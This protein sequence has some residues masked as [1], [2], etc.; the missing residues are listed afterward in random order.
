MAYRDQVMGGYAA[1]SSNVPEDIE[2][3]FSKGVPGWMIDGV[4]PKKAHD[5][6]IPSASQILKP[7]QQ[8]PTDRF[9]GNLVNSKATHESGAD[10]E[11][12]AGEE[13]VRLMMSLLTRMRDRLRGE[14]AQY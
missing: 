4:I 9:L 7:S 12:S 5:F 8:P 1:Q 6:V 10:P 14:L 11:D 2:N 3:R 13:N